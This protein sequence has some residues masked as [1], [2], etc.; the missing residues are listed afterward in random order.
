MHHIQSQSPANFVYEAASQLSQRLYSR[1]CRLASIALNEM[2][3][4]DRQEAD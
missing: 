1:R 4:F 3:D 2:G